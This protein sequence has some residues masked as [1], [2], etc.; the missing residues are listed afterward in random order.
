[1]TTCGTS[2]WGWLRRL[3]ASARFL[4]YARTLHPLGLTFALLF[5]VWSMSPSLLPR[6]WYLQGVATGI[7]VA[8]GYG[9]GCGI[10]WVVRRCGVSPQWTQRTRTIG[11]RALAVTA[12]VV[13]PTFVVPEVRC[14]H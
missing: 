8:I 2:Q 13:V 3:S 7:S 1:M 10:A 12:L 6:P 5:F 9:L 11:W 4:D 14:C